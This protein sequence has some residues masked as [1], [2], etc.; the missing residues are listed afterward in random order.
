MLSIHQC[1]EFAHYKP[2]SFFFIRKEGLVLK[3]VVV[4]VSWCCHSSYIWAAVF[5]GIYWFDI[6]WVAVSWQKLYHTK[7]V[8]LQITDLYNYL[9]LMYTK[10]T[11]CVFLNVRIF[12]FS[13]KFSGCTDRC[14]SRIGCSCSSNWHYFFFIYLKYHLVVIPHGFYACFH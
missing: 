5:K 11:S 8:I 12:L 1:S 10:I 6:T 7:V 14:W 4:F 9:I 2:R 3:V 13:F